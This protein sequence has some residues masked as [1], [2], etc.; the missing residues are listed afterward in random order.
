MTSHENWEKE[1]AIT[2]AQADP[3]AEKGQEI[4]EKVDASKLLRFLA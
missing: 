3:L 4:K 1:L 2:A